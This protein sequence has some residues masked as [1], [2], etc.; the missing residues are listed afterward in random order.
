MHSWRIAASGLMTA[1]LLAAPTASPAHA[2]LRGW[3]EVATVIVPELNEFWSSTLYGYAPPQVVVYNQPRRWRDFQT[4]CGPVD[5]SEPNAFFCAA[6]GTVYLNAEFV[7]Q[8]LRRYGDMA[9]VTLIAHEFGHVAAHEAGYDQLGL[10]TIQLELQADCFAGLFA[11]Y[12]ASRGYLEPGDA[13]EAIR[14]QR[15]AADPKGTSPRD[16]GAHGDAQ[17]R[18]GWFARGATT[19]NAAA[20][21]TW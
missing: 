2:E 12:A 7:D 5:T 1:L 15:S 10:Y 9:A 20:C 16:P 14:G 11:N 8:Q 3:R 6:D 4:G 13:A 17:E 18:M 21:Q 19:G